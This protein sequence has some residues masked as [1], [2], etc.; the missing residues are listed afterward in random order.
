MADSPGD[1]TTR[2]ARMRALLETQLQPTRLEIID[3]SAA[4]HGH[5]SAGGLGHFRLRIASQRFAGLST[6]ARHRLVNETLAPLYRSDIH[7]LS[8]TASVE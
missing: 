5:A 3:D 7:A 8:I 4:H 2:V 6:L 1:P